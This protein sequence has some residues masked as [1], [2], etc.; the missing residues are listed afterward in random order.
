[1]TLEL[2]KRQFAQIDNFF[3]GLRAGAKLA[4]DRAMLRVSK[5]FEKD[6]RAGYQQVPKAVPPSTWTLKHPRCVRAALS[7]VAAS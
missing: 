7:V 1:V 6:V 5:Q 2:N 3:R 4:G